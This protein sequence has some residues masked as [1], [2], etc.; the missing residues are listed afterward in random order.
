MSSIVNT[1]KWA[2]EDYYTTTSTDWTMHE[3][4]T[5]HHGASFNVKGIEFTTYTKWESFYVGT[6]I[7][8]SFVAKNL[9]KK[10]GYKTGLLLALLGGVESNEFV[11]KGIR[12]IQFFQPTTQTHQNVHYDSWTTSNTNGVT[13]QSLN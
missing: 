2:T 9:F 4:W 8:N 5:Q 3:K 1:S 10:H 6:K 13:W 7:G 12:P 11:F